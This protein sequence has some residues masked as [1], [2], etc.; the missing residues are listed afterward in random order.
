MALGEGGDGSCFDLRRAGLPSTLRSFAAMSAIFR[1]ASDFAGR[2]EGLRGG[3]TGDARVPAALR[4]RTRLATRSNLMQMLDAIRY[5][6]LP[7]S[8]LVLCYAGFTLELVFCQV[9]CFR[10]RAYGL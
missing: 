10:L 7:E 2:K 4:L 8:S 3:T 5:A 1:L 9:R 6:E